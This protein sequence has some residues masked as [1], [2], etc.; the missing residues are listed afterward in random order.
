MHPLQETKVQGGSIIGTL[1]LTQDQRP[2][3]TWSRQQCDGGTPSCST[4]TAVYHTECLYDIDSDHRRKGALKRDIESLK[5]RNGALAVIVNSIRSSSETEVAEIVQQ[6]RADE[7]LE[8]LAE[9]LKRNILLPRRSGSQSL[10]ADLSDIM[11]RPSLSRSGQTRHFG[12]TSSLG[13]VDEDDKSPV[14]ALIPSEAW[15]K[16]TRD[17]GLVGHLMA[18]YFCWQHPVF[19]LLSKE[20]FL[21]DM[22]K[23]RTKYCSPLLVNALLSVACGFSDRPELR[24]D[25][26]DS[27]T[28][29]DLFFAEARRLL[30]EDESS[31]LTTVQA[32]AL[33]GLR[34]VSCGRDSSG[35]HYTGR[36][37]RMA[38]E[39]GLHLADVNPALT[40]TEV[41]VRKITFWGCF[42]LD[43]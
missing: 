40:P 35:F 23:G 14:R 22:S 7:N 30:F 21:H 33:M 37:I 6:I 4:C 8:A 3:N 16:V 19:V 9:S 1:S 32:L 31:S 28:A 39:L 12:H 38:I 36:C 11:G 17:A 2:T 24:T 20:C 41:E 26:D 42:T 43:T 13:L 18:L 15:T 27:K 10:E 25:P 34:E 5:E 29:G